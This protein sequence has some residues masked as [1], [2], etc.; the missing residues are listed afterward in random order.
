MRNNG[1]RMYDQGY[2]RTA[3][4]PQQPPT[5]TGL[6]A[7]AMSPQKDQIVPR[8]ELPQQQ[9]HTF[10]NVAQQGINQMPIREFYKHVEQTVPSP[11]PKIAANLD[12]AI[13]V[14]FKTR[15]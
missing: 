9:V 7:T 12:S 13:L 15:Y 4:G 1:Q 3:N 8:F 2:E 10:E 5:A 14:R 6:L 11:P